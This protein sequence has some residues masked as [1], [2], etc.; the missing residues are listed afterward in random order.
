MK[1]NNIFELKA[2]AKNKPVYTRMMELKGTSPRYSDVNYSSISQEGYMRNW[3]M[4][5]CVQ[6]I[7]KAAVQLN[8][9]VMRY[10]SNGEPEEVKNHP[11]VQIIEK[12]NA[13][14]GQSELIKR[15]I[16]F[17]YI[18]GE[19]PFHKLVAGGNPKEMYVYRPDR[20][21]FTSSGDMEQPYQNIRYNEI[22]DIEPENFMLWKN[23]NPLD[24]FDG[25][26]HGMSMLEPI[27][28]NG[29]LLNEMVNWNI[30]LLQNGGNLSGVIALNE[31]VSD[32][33]YERM[34]EQLKNKHQGVDNVGKYLLMQG[35]A[36]YVNT[37]TSPKD[38][39]WIQ[40]KESVMLDTCIG[41]GVD[42]IIIGF[43]KQSSYN[44]KN[45]AEKGLY[46]KTVIPLMKELA[47]QLN[48][49]LGLKDSEYLDIDYSSIPC[50]QEDMKEMAEVL[51][52]AK[53]MTINEKRVKRGLEPIEGGDIIAPEGSFAIVDGKVYLPMNLIELGAGKEDNADITTADK[54][55]N[56]SFMY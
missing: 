22:T 49:F 6:E 26:G 2:S 55:E 25:L 53:D 47:D 36:T 24:D 17:Y 45:E 21:K 46:T 4:F 28:K 23:F 5:R 38:M 41:I 44:N 43:N 51:A 16:A 10:K 37:G 3:I 12:P 40:G 14:Y 20:I 7:M 48:N 13:L 8:W 11:A 9:K 56:K 18:G 30:S 33:Q 52:K 27:L 32:D 34:E 42:P 50:L 31:N 19:A 1:L 29:D 35:V 54:D 39:D 15:A